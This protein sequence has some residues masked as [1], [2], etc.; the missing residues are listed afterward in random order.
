[1]YAFGMLAL[2]GLAVLVVASVAA[3]FLSA[4]QEFWAFVLVALAMG[5]AWLAD[6][7]I[8]ESWG[9]AVRNPTIGVTLTGFMIAGVA[10]FWRELLHFFA[11]LSRKFSDEAATLEKTQHLRRVA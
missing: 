10:Y 2:L 1:M 8:F 11:G 3:R 4:A 6:F 7:N 9:L 5:A